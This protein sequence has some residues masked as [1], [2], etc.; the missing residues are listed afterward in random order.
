[1]CSSDLYVIVALVAD[2]SGIKRAAALAQ[3]QRARALR[4]CLDAIPILFGHGRSS[5]TS[6]PERPDAA[7]GDRSE[8]AGRHGLR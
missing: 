2:E 7:K 8:I 1:V 6:G 4:G 5:M 3:Q